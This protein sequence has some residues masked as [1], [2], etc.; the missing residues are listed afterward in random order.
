MSTGARIIL[1]D[2][3]FEKDM[4]RS[5]SVTEEFQPLSLTVPISQLEVELFSDD[6]DFSI[7]DP[8]GDYS[9]LQYR[10]PMSVIEVID[11][12]ER[13]IGRYYLDV[14]EN[15]TDNLIKLVCM[16]EIGL[17]DTVTYRGGLWLEPIT[18][19]E[20]LSQMF[21]GMDVDYEIDPDLETA[22][23]TGWIPICTYREALQQICFA[24]GSYI[25]CARQNGIIKFGRIDAIGAV[26]RG[27]YC[28][29]PNAGR[30]RVWKKRF[31]QSQWGGV[32]PVYDIPNSQQ[33]TDQKISLRTQVT[34]VEISMH[35]ITLG[36]AKRK[37]FEGWLEP[38][39]HEIRFSQPMHSVTVSGDAILLESPY[40]SANYAGVFVLSPGNVLVEGLVYN[41]S[42]TKY[43]VY[44]DSSEVVKANVLTISDASMVNSGNGPEIAQRVFDYYQR[45]HVQDVKLIRPSAY[46]GSEVLADTLY[47]RKINGV[48][49]KMT[50]D[51]TGGYVGKTTI[52]GVPVEE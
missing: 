41:D 50:T 43:G 23:L 11:G 5:A 27:I 48:I 29:V 12:S 39:T 9:L 19:G 13:F 21:T 1:A 35:D 32:M 2:T 16:D 17:L 40:N 6:T 28:G 25:L 14:W 20:L 38:G 3:V 22:P 15:L 45:R 42:I 18:M 8:S 46:I 34:G 33:S 24:A 7:I 30:T 47:G 26:T 51:L 10:Q 52:V 44:M 36:D 31:R 37:L 4:I 49:E